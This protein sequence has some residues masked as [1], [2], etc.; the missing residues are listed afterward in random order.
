VETSHSRFEWLAQAISL[1]F[2][3]G[4]EWTSHPPGRV[5][6]SDPKFETTTNSERTINGRLSGHM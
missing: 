5:C 1:L 2:S 6:A 4:V 3:V